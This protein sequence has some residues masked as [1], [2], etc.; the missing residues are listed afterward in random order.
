MCFFLVL[1]VCPGGLGTTMGCVGP[2]SAIEVRNGMTFLDLTVRQIEV[3]PLKHDKG[4]CNKTHLSQYLN[5]EYD[6][7]VP[8]ILMNSFNTDKD[9]AKIIQKYS[10]HKV[11]KR[12][13]LATGDTNLFCALGPHHH[14]QPEPIP[15]LWQGFPH[16]YSQLVHQW[17]QRLV[18]REQLVVKQTE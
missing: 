6:V 10:T 14:L 5:A 15:S 16:A 1:T 9:T 7:D 2:K 18:L 4:G 3:H 11:K 13:E 8:L 12:S 17:H